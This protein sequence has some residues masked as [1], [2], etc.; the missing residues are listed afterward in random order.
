MAAAADI[1]TC[2]SRKVC[3]SADPTV[4][5]FPAANEENMSKAI[6]SIPVYPGVTFG[7]SGR[8]SFRSN[9]TGR[10]SEKGRKLWRCRGNQAPGLCSRFHV[11]KYTKWLAEISANHSETQQIVH[12]VLE[13][14]ITMEILIWELVPPPVLV[15]ECGVQQSGKMM[16]QVW[17]QS[18]GI[19]FPKK[20]LTLPDICFCRF[21]CGIRSDW[22]SVLRL[23]CGLLENTWQLQEV[24]RFDEYLR[25]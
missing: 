12:V 9:D 4:F 10:T 11:S 21:P 19:N 14:I 3:R 16:Y 5:F 1:L 22:N 2:R 7:E 25:D 20:N 15:W 18:W 23:P 17:T 6:G 24:K 8:E 13:R